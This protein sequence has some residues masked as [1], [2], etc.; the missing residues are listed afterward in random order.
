VLCKPSP[1]LQDICGLLKKSNA[2]LLEQA[3]ARGNAIDPTN[4]FSSGPVPVPL[5]QDLLECLAHL[6]SGSSDDAKDGQP[7]DATK[8][9]ELEEEEEEELEQTCKPKSS[10]R[11]VKK[12]ALK[13]AKEQHQN[14]EMLARALDHIEVE[15]EASS[16]QKKLEAF[17]KQ[18]EYGAIK[19]LEQ[20]V[21]DKYRRFRRATPRT[22]ILIMQNLAVLAYHHGQELKGT[23]SLLEAIK[24]YELSFQC[25]RIINEDDDAE[26]SWPYKDR[27]LHKHR[28]IAGVS[29][30]YRQLGHHDRAKSYLCNEV[31]VIKEAVALQGTPEAKGSWLCN[32]GECH[33]SIADLSSDATEG[34]E[35]L[36]KA[37]RAF[38]EAEEK[39]SAAQEGHAS[40]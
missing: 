19:D 16:L 17:C 21:F 1:P 27:I 37:L 25:C 18:H 35:S 20:E 28:S 34:D 3:S 9:N 10:D 12:R 13:A 14:V 6:M 8:A 4:L 29:E 11:S 22:A 15:K 23:G 5:K 39:S 26:T 7:S 31:D 2:I 40:G 32:L 33:A 24:A 36:E 30:C 38:A